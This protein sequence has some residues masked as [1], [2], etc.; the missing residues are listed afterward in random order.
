M[1]IQII[2]REAC[3]E[4]AAAL[5]WFLP[6][7]TLWGQTAQRSHCSHLITSM[8]SHN[9]PPGGISQRGGPTNTLCGRRDK[10]LVV[11][12][13]HETYVE[14]SMVAEVRIGNFYGRTERMRRHH[15]HACKYGFL[16]QAHCN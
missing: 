9:K 10:L 11:G 12:R 5:G 7:L 4:R 13:T 1:Q 3:A 15:L 8:L 2:R 16:I 6:F 14:K